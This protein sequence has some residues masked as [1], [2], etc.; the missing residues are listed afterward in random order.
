MKDLLKIAAVLA[1]VFA[2]TFVLMNSTGL[3]TEAG[4]EHFLKQAKSINPLW[5]A[6]L[7]IG[8]LLVD[9]LI[10]VPTMATILLAGYLMG[11]V[12]GGLAS[13]AGLMLLGITG[14]GMGFRLGRPV[15]SRL[16]RD[17]RRLPEI[18]SAF[19]RNDLL[20][21]F[22]CQAL[23]ILP[24]LSC[25]LAGISQMRFSR[26]LFGYAVGVVPFA[27]IVAYAGSVSTVAD[28]SP[29]IYTAIAVSVALL[30]AWTILRKRTD[31]VP[32]R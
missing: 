10:A 21:L 32:S 25:T 8:L 6:A 28:P 3:V 2:S 30:L 13:A 19:A 27:F 5:L 15:L 11:P 29:A 7:V 23:P 14:Y 12:A 31:S 9:L 26:F 17:D 22:I 16:F 18:E 20:V 24:E 4:V 1:V